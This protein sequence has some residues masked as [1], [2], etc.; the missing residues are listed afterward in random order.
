MWMKRMNE[1]IYA[2]W[3][4]ELNNMIEWLGEPNE[5]VNG[6]TDKCKTIINKNNKE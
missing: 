3:M 6:W 5:W 2:D 1:L 4:S